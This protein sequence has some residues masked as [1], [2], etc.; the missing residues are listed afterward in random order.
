MNEI[1]LQCCNSNFNAL[2][3]LLFQSFLS[4]KTIHYSLE[5]DRSRLSPVFHQNRF[6]FTKITRARLI[7]LKSA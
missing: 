7:S 1:L 4:S 2:Y 6:I 3:L 5:G